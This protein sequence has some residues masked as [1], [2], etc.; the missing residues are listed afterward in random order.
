[1]LRQIR[2]RN[3][4]KFNGSREQRLDFPTNGVYIFIGENNAGKSCIFEGIRRCMQTELNDTVSARH[5]SD[6]ISYVICKFEKA[7]SDML[8]SCFISYKDG[9]DATIRK[10]V[11][12]KSDDGNIITHSISRKM[13]SR[14]GSFKEVTL[15]D[16]KDRLHKICSQLLDVKNKD[17]IDLTHFIEFC[18]THISDNND[19]RIFDRAFENINFETIFANRGISPIQT[20]CQI[21]LIENQNIYKSSNDLAY[22][23]KTYLNDPDESTADGSESHYFRCLTEPQ[24]YKFE[25]KDNTN[26]TEIMVTSNNDDKPFPI[27]KAPE[28]ILEAKMMSITLSNKRTTTLLIDEPGRGMHPSMIDCL[29]DLVLYDVNKNQ[30][31]TV[32]FTTHNQRFICPW[33][34]ENIFYFYSC[35]SGSKVVHLEHA[36]KKNEVDKKEYLW[37]DQVSPILFSKRVIMVEGEDDIRFLSTLKNVLLTDE[38]RRWLVCKEDPETDLK[39]RKFLISLHIVAMGGKGSAKGIEPLCKALNLTQRKLRY[40]LFDSDALKTIKSSI[41]KTELNKS[42]IENQKLEKL[43]EHGIFVWFGYTDGIVEKFEKLSVIDLSNYGRLE[44][45]LLEFC[46]THD[47][48]HHDQ[49]NR[50]CKLKDCKGMNIFLKQLGLD[51]A[52]NRNPNKKKPIELKN[53]DYLQLRDLTTR[54]IDVSMRHGDGCSYRDTHFMCPFKRLWQFL[55]NQAK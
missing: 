20:S 4:V 43:E 32:I 7:N 16:D 49:N 28:G 36:I 1:M 17:E 25:F 31:K 8:T 21:P 50:N 12:N 37:S 39:L 23:I 13:D 9:T 5:N 51:V 54:I 19:I 55:I 40:Y 34:F 38:I 47:K 33:T 10:I 6:N 52:D 41:M 44:D 14:W 30:V 29:R 2:L 42:D 22:V 46:N 53:I 15:S 35:E 27:L 11:L 18:K 24:S 3:F 45:A 48:I 26:K